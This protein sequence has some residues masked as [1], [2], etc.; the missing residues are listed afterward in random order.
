MKRNIR[1]TENLKISDLPSVDA[2]WDQLSEFA[3]TFDPVL[4]IGRWI[5]SKNLLLFNNS[6]SVKELRTYLYFT[7]RVWHDGPHEIT[8]SSLDEMRSSVL[9]IR[10]KLS[11]EVWEQ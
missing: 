8:E 6:S 10:S 9:L 7:Q 1:R 2:S 5:W 11:K 3:L 4:E